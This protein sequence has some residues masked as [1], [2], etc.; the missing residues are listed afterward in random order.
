ML[1]ETKNKDTMQFFKATLECIFSPYCAQA[2]VDKV[3]AKRKSKVPWITLPLHG[4]FVCLF[5]AVAFTTV[6]FLNLWFDARM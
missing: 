5:C 2:E 6:C 4:G 1:K 3:Q